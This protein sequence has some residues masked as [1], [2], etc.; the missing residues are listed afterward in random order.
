MAI[1]AGRG[2]ISVVLEPG[3][4]KWCGCGSSQNQPFCDGSHTG[5]DGPKRFTVQETLQTYLCM[6]KQT[7]N[8]PYCDG[9]H[10][11]LN[12]NQSQIQS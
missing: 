1:A 7:Q 8:S 12:L 3:L 6:C 11:R 10:K 4:H 5:S 2:P 9:S